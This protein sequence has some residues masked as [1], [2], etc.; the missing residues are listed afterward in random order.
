MGIREDLFSKLVEKTK[1]LGRQVTASELLED[2]KKDDRVP[3]PNDYAFYY[4]S[5]D[6]AARLAY[7]RGTPWPKV[8][9]V[10]M[11]MKRRR[12]CP[13]SEAKQESIIA[14]L[15]DMYIANNGVMP[16]SKQIKKNR[17][18]KEQDVD[19]MRWAGLIDE[20]DIRRRAEE[21]SGKRFLTPTERR[22]QGI[23]AVL[24]EEVKKMNE[25]EVV[26]GI[27]V[28]KEVHTP[29]EVTEKLEESKLKEPKRKHRPHIKKTD[30]QLWAEIREKCA[31]AGH[32]LTDA[33][34]N[35]DETLSSASTYYGHL[36]GDY[37]RVIFLEDVPVEEAKE[38]PIGVEEPAIEAKEESIEIEESAIEVKEESG[39][40]EIPFKL[41]IPK[42]I[43][44]TVTLNLEF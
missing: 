24:P 25:E 30:E 43:K 32:I 39:L 31:Q 36:G 20:S 10:D 16:S 14:E 23:V 18:I 37:K 13:L 19:T 34:I 11:V 8:E 33:E 1:K 5:F 29:K 41:I 35:M 4:G 9:E 3:D 38:G 12:P 40:R 7:A 42:G 21:K 17:C 15:V 26:R 2:K 28:V 22:Q 44:G 6:E 27:D